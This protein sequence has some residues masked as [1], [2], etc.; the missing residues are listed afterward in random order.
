MQEWFRRGPLELP[1]LPSQCVP[2]VASQFR[3]QPR[4]PVS[5]A[6]AFVDA[7]STNRNAAHSIV[8]NRGAHPR[9]SPLHP[10]SSGQ[11]LAFSGSLQSRLALHLLLVC[12][13]CST[14]HSRKDKAELS[15]KTVREVKTTATQTYVKV[16]NGARSFPPPSICLLHHDSRL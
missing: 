8:Q 2:P 3:L 12:L 14:T 1:P 5:L 7:L 9:N 15:R 16:D 13:A 4:Q 6:T 11:R 10:H